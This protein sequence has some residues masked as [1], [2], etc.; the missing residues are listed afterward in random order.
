MLDSCPA[1]KIKTDVY[2]LFSASELK[3][4]VVAKQRSL[5]RAATCEI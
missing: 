4:Y 5:D 1:L 3:P 2:L